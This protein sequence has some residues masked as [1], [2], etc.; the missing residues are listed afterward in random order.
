MRLARTGPTRKCGNSP[1][2]TGCLPEPTLV[3][4][5]SAAA[6][7]GLARRRVGPLLRGGQLPCRLPGRLLLP[8]L[9]QP[10]LAVEL[11]HRRLALVASGHRALLER[12]DVGGRWAL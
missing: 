10:A 9:E 6:P 3:Y 5:P 4:V 12:L 2:L 11:C 7:A 1:T 8:L